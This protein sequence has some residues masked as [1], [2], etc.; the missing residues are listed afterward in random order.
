M[1]WASVEEVEGI[2]GKEFTLSTV[3][4][5]SAMIDT[6]TG[7]DEE[8]P[9]DAITLVDRRHLRKATAWQC[10][11]AVKP[12]L[13]EERENA[14]DMSSDS[15]RITREDRADIVLHPMARR[16]I[17]NLSWV[18]TRTVILPPVSPATVHVNFLNEG[19]DSNGIWSPV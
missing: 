14:L 13:L 11:F 9:E 8:M 16:E 19:S 2:T 15:Q 5:A 17:L 12:G 4:L 7:A 3:A 1:A 6:F 10:F 18:G